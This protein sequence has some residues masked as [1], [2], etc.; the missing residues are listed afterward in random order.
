MFRVISKSTSEKIAEFT[1]FQEAKSEAQS[2]EYGFI[3]DE[4]TSAF[5]FVNGEGIYRDTKTETEVV[6]TFPL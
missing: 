6:I 5:I 2:D 3:Y 1:T 4:S